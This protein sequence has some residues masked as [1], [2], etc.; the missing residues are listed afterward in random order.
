L[1]DPALDE[2]LR[3]AVFAH[4]QQLRASHGERIPA[5]ELS[6]GVAFRGERVPIWS[7]RKGI[8]KPAALGRDGAALSIQTSADSPY[9]DE[10]DPDVGHFIY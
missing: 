8:F 2:E 7:Q 3:A 10:R 9:A 5:A 6:A 4:V 1:L